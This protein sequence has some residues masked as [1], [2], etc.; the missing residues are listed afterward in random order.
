M[1]LYTLKIDV[2]ELLLET[3]QEHE[4]R[5]FSLINQI[6]NINYVRSQSPHEKVN[7][8]GGLNGWGSPQGSPSHVVT[9]I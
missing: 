8:G 3:I 5:A 4:D 9:V 1:R 6:E 2:L 7:P